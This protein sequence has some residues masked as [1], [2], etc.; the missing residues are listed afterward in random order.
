M[1]KW[2]DLTYRETISLGV[3]PICF[4]NHSVKLKSLNRFCENQKYV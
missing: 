4:K 2:H 3:R 1:T